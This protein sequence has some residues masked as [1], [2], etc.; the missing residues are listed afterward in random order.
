MR[1][2]SFQN[3][4]DIQLSR[5]VMRALIASTQL[6]WPG[7]NAS[8]ITNE[9]HNRCISAKDYKGCVEAQTRSQLQNS[10]PSQADDEGKNNKPQPNS[11]PVGFAY[12]GSGYCTEVY[13]HMGAWFIQKELDGK[14]WS[15]PAVLFGSQKPKWGRIT[16]PA[17]YDPN[18]PQPT[19]DWI[20]WKNTCAQSGSSK[21]PEK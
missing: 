20:G 21:A 7:A 3:M 9:I 6:L 14:G 5:L 17:G 1:L 18:C 11:C 2:G 13:C 16:I 19:A 8:T 15:C 4:V 10:S 12:S